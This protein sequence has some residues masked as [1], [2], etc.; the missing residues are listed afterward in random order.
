M[1]IPH[2]QVIEQGILEVL[3]DDREQIA[4]VLRNAVAT[5]LRLTKKDLE[6]RR[7]NSPTT[8]WINEHAWALVDLQNPAPLGSIIKTG[9]RSGHNIYQITKRGK[10]RLRDLSRDAKKRSA[11]TARK[12]ST[13]PR[14]RSTAR[15][16]SPSNEA[17]GGPLTDA[18]R[19][20]DKQRGRTNLD[21]FPFDPEELDR[22]TV[23]HM[24]LQ[25]RLARMAKNAGFKVH[26]PR[27]GDP[28]QFDLAWTSASG[29]AV[30]EVK[31]LS[32]TNADAKQIRLGI[33]QV[34]EY[35][36]RLRAAG[37]DVLAILVVDRKPAAA[38]WVELCDRHDIQL[39]WPK[40][41]SALFA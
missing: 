21:P 2:R 3:A 23:E 17:F 16:T 7:G 35:Q 11:S 34:L 41:L 31:T 37:E 1:A 40:T 6:L 24:Q 26:S 25:D 10:M 4:F 9:T 33:G 19:P 22:K 13:E 32:T 15:S 38:H 8:F 18:Y 14:G 20:V 12:R 27:K 36:H 29:K 28:V 5:R 39:A 30:V